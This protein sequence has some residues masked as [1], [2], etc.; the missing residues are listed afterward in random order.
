[1]RISSFA[2]SIFRI[3]LLF[4]L[5]LA[6]S[7]AYSQAYMP[8]PQTTSVDKWDVGLDLGY[9]QFYGDVS[10]HNYFQKLSGESRIGVEVYA[11]RMFNPAVGAG[12]GL[13]S[14]GL[15]SIK[16]K[17]NGKTVSY[18]MGGNFDDLSVFAYADFSNLIGNY[19]S[20]RK[21]S[22]YGKLGLGVSIWNTGLTNNITGSIIRSGTTS[23]STKYANKALCV[24][25]GAGLDYR[26]N[27]HWAVHAGGTFTTVLS[28][29]VDLWHGGFKYDQLFYT[30][31]GVTYYI[32][33]GHHG[34]L[35]GENNERTRHRRNRR[36]RQINKA[37]IP[38]FDYM[39]NPAPEVTPLKPKLDELHVP[40]KAPS[41]EKA[42][43]TGVQFRIQIMASRVRLDPVL[44]QAKYKFDYPVKEVH[45]D[46]YYRYTIGQFRTYQQAL[47]ECRK[48]LGMGVHGAFVTAYRNGQRI[49]LTYKMMR[50]G[51][52]YQQPDQSSGRII[53]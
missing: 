5:V 7:G 9:T 27:D 25:L 41:G 44:L 18:T 16:D 19:R 46:G 2:T 33:P 10:S 31:V 50:K 47:T 51:F 53:F 21:L 48:I 29:D 34:S 36:K 11:R 22:V 6:V 28:D 32:Q 49:P 8:S 23:G 4:V 17:E 42:T 30:H 13:F 1:M 3:L 37:S 12:I 52:N 15:R 26:I 14:A 40:L 35:L 43:S 45:Q 39:V 20:S 38:I 24:P